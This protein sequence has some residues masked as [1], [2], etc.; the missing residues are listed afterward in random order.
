MSADE[1]AAV[2]RARKG[3]A[4]VLAV[5]RLEAGELPVDVAEAWLRWIDLVCV[6]MVAGAAGV[7]AR[8]DGVGGLVALGALA[9]GGVLRPPSAWIVGAQG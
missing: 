7:V 3:A 2:M 5:A 1:R 8:K 6:A 4:A 9:G